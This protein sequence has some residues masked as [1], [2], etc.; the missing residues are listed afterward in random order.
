MFLGATR[1]RDCDFARMGRSLVLQNPSTVA[2]RREGYAHLVFPQRPAMP[3]RYDGGAGPSPL[4]WMFGRT[5]MTNWQADLDALVQE[6][7][8]LTKSVRVEP[9]M[10]RAVVEPN[11][12]PA[13]LD[14][15]ERD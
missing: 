8:A 13:N 7:M 5:N 10:T 1:Q 11:R 12:M 2:R 6:T 9:T 15:S 4:G 3:A 14:R